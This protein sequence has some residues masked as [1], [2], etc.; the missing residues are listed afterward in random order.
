MK[1]FLFAWNP[2]KWNWTTLEQ[3][4]NQIEQTGRATEKWSVISHR[5]I[6]PG[7]RAFL[8]RLGKEPKGIMAAGF[9]ATPPFLIKH[10]SRENKMVNRVMIDFEVILN[11]EYEPLLSLNILNEGK[12][13]KINW[14]PQSSGVEINSEITDELEAI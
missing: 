6:Q 3:S 5:K 13:A 4:I 11:P 10:W 9:V 1:T 2:K 7:D 14:T 8:M 12:L